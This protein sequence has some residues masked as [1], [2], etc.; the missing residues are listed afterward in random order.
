MICIDRL[1]NINLAILDLKRVIFEFLLPH[2][3]NSY[4][5]F[6]NIYSG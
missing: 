1:C 5:S 2:T 4:E 6:Y 3:H